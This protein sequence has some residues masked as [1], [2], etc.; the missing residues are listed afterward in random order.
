MHVLPNYINGADV[1]SSAAERTSIVDPTTGEVYC[2]S[3][4][5]NAADVDAAMKS[6]AAAFVSW[7]QTTPSER[8]AYLLKVADALEARADELVSA[9]CKNCG[10]PPQLTL[11][12]EITMMLDQI[13]FFAGACRHPRHDAL[14]EG[15]RGRAR[16]HAT[17]G[18]ALD[19][20]KG[21]TQI[22]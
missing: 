8:M 1:E 18:D 9:E 19:A 22:R 2:L 13:R 11:D 15:T 16:D 20:L 21:R 3:P 17:L 14:A 5:S 6:A 10:K 4:K 12:E 7:R